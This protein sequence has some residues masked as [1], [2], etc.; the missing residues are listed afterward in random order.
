MPKPSP[1][2]LHLHDLRV[3]LVAQTWDSTSIGNLRYSVG[4]IHQLRGQNE[5]NVPKITVI[6]PPGALS[7]QELEEISFWTRV[8]VV[9]YSY[10]KEFSL[11]AVKAAFVQFKLQGEVLFIQYDYAF[12]KINS[13]IAQANQLKVQDQA[14]LFSAYQ[15]GIDILTG[16][17]EKTKEAGVIQVV[18]AEGKVAL[19]GVSSKKLEAEA[20][21]LDAVELGLTHASKLM[22]V[23]FEM[24]CRQAISYQRFEEIVDTLV[25][26]DGLELPEGYVKPRT[27]AIGAPC[28]GKSMKP[29]SDPYFISALVKSVVATVTE[30]EMNDPNTNIVFYVAFDHGDLYYDDDAKRA[31]LRALF[32]EVTAPYADKMKLLL[33]RIPYTGRVAMLWSMLYLYSIRYDNI[34][35]FYQVN[36]DLT[37]KTK[38]WLTTFTQKLDSGVQVVGPSD[39]HNRFRCILL[40]QAMVTPRHYEI[41]GTLYPLALKDWKTDRWLTH[42]YDKEPGATWCSVDLVADNGAAVTRYKH[43]EFLCWYF[44]LNNGRK[45]VRDAFAAAEAE[46]AIQA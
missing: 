9:E 2:G 34:Q 32:A 5:E 35:Y 10:D 38:G 44:Y 29:D 6:V 11:E 3:A 40:T 23:D 45:M 28:T 27:I 46:Q 17:Y 4:S 24:V 26:V 25:E 13:T 20:T 43:C 14:L 15:T 18:D 16:L 22:K 21:N 7:T 31:S 42:V 33:F 37:M 39:N 19:V 41:F 8:T 12:S 36:D 1:S 30:E